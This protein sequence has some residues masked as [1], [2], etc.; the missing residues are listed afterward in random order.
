MEDGNEN[1]VRTKFSNDSVASFFYGLQ[2]RQNACNRK[3]SY[4]RLV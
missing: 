4:C 3:N 2:S 1:F